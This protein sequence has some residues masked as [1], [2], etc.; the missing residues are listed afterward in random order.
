V[1]GV[2][3]LGEG[4]SIEQLAEFHQ[5]ATWFSLMSV[6]TMISPVSHE[7][8]EAVLDGAAR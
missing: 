6:I 8:Y 4:N 1:G 2:T 3:N 5:Q 7:K